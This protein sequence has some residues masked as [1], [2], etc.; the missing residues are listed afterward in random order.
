MKPVCILLVFSAFILPS[1]IAL[2]QGP[3][4]IIPVPSE[5]I[6][7]EGT[8]EFAEVPS[9]STRRVRGIAPES[10]E[11][12]VNE[13]GVTIKASDDAGEFY[14]FQTLKQMTD[15]GRVKSIRCCEI[16][17]SPRFPYRGLHF[18]VSRHFRSI[19]FLKKQMDAMAMFKMNR[20]HI[21]LTDA[22]GWRIQIEAYP[23]LT[24][25]AA[26]RPQHTWK[27]WWEGDR[28]YAEEG[29]PGSYGGYYTKDELHNLVSYARA[30]HI[31]IIP[32]IE[33]PSH[34]E[35]V[36]AAYPELGCS[37][38]PYKDSDFCVGNEEVFAFLETV[39]DEVME[40]F[41]YEYIHIGGDEAGKQH[42]KTCPK[43]QKRMQ[44]ED[45][46]DVDE[47]QSYMI[48]R[49]ARYVES[50]GRKVIGWDEIL[51]GGLAEGA[52]V[53]SW[54]GTEG[55]IAAM[56]MGHDV[57]MSPGRYC[58]LDHAQDAPFKEPESI[59]GYLP[60][61]SV[62]TYEPLEPS[63]PSDRIHHLKG[64]QANL[65]TEYI[66]TDEQA[67]YMYWPRAIAI[68]ETGWSLPENKDLKG[69]RQRVLHMLEIMRG[70]DYETFD[71]E[72]EYG[73][74][75]E[76]V[77]GAGHLAKGCKVIYHTPVRE[78]YPAAGET[79]FTDGIMGGWTYSDGRWQG[80]LSDIDVTI[81]LGAVKPVTYVGG[82]F[83][84]LK[85]PGVF[86]PRQVEVLASEDGV[87]Y[88]RLAV[89]ENDVPV[90]AEDLR[91][92]SFDTSCEIRARY[93]RYHASR[94]TMRGFLFLDEII[95]N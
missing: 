49:I 5:V 85:G 64:V 57:V 92:R 90:S 19:D 23:R 8:Y 65:W 7:R 25:F 40:V 71:L 26:W 88:K 81:D 9:V 80:F 52:A 21:H 56:N 48:K 77:T 28:H 93:I 10:Y 35:E 60:L 16:T 33:M 46:K 30:R 13:R 50:K 91:F 44:E 1:F 87:E 15:D 70:K 27:E 78:W 39:L 36:L 76:A 59:G 31:E 47:L 37:G 45:L 74:R 72:N 43:C 67:E 14:A 89:I 55:G 20:M 61:D 68:A 63:M 22:A 58:Y 42:W 3:E 95:V 41:P 53:M 69:F 12:K 38:E 62:Y 29:T 94:S 6:Y 75:K 4:V 11:M 17:D 18:D 51:D 66:V 32:E 2:A 54:R 84:Q 73:E 79:T 34:S 82:T 24:Q 83:M 86:M